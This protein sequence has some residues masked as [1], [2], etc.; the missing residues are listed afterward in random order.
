MDVLICHF[1]PM[2]SWFLPPAPSI[3]IGA[4]NWLGLTSKFID[5]AKIQAQTQTTPDVWAQ[6]IVADNPKLVAF[7]LF[8]F[9]SQEI[10]RELASE[11]KKL[12]PNIKIIAGGPGIKELL[13]QMI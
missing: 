2:F 5:F 3:L 6:N 7:S 4:C 11:I 12:N 1:P 10:S 8:S 9:Q 13:I